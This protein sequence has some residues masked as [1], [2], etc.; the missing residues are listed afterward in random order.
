MKEQ[1][2]STAANWHTKQ[3]VASSGSKQQY[4]E[5]RSA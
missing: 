3:E 5:M 2:T 1:Q 4:S